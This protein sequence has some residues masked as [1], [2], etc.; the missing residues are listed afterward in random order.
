MKNRK[1]L[2]TIPEVLYSKLEKKQ[3]S[4]GYLSIQEAVSDILREKLLVKEKPEKRG[5][6]KKIDEKE[7]LT[8]KGKIWDKE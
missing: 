4:E 5:R 8:G 6:P 2:L 3:K 1:I 7:I